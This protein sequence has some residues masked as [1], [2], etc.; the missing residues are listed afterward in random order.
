MTNEDHIPDDPE[1]SQQSQPANPMIQRFVQ[2]FSKLSVAGSSSGTG[3]KPGKTTQPALQ[4]Q[5][6]ILAHSGQGTQLPPLL[7]HLPS[8]QRSKVVT[9]QY[10]QKDGQQSDAA[11]TPSGQVQVAGVTGTSPP[12]FLHSSEKPCMQQFLGPQQL[13]RP[14]S[15]QAQIKSAIQPVAQHVLP[16]KE[17][18]RIQDGRRPLRLP[19]R[20]TISSPQNTIRHSISKYRQTQDSRSAGPQSHKRGQPCHSFRISPPPKR[21]AI[22]Q[23]GESGRPDR[24]RHPSP[25]LSSTSD[26]AS[27]H[28]SS[29]PIMDQIDD[30]PLHSH[31]DRT[32]PTDPFPVYIP[33]H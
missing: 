10:G 28:Q 7:S 26:A 23:D 24:R 5:Q 27:H 12:Q 3:L 9:V 30:A 21:A 19:G 4:L 32:P 33:P 31:D 20:A 16:Q 22:T 14:S 8:L 29:A 11:T 17:S 1:E 13:S 15:S 18:P 25:A 6:S 2:Y